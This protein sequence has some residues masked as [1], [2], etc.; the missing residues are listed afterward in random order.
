M[1]PERKLRRRHQNHCLNSG[2]T[3]F[4]VFAS[5][6]VS[7]MAHETIRWSPL[8]VPMVQA[9]QVRLAIESK[10]LQVSGL[11]GILLRPPNV[12]GRGDGH[13]VFWMIKAAAQKL[14]AVP[15]ITDSGDG[16]WSFVHVMS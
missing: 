11:E 1:H 4:P 6:A 10:V 13:S 16:L 15:F 14:G 5:G 9:L 8:H 2:D 12:Y 7:D 3:A